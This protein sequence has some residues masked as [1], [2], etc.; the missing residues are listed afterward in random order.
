[1]PD[2]ADQ[3]QAQEE[4]F[5]GQALARQACSAGA[6]GAA[7]RSAPARCVECDDAIGIERRQA[8]PHACRCATCA[9]DHEYRLQVR[10]R[11]G[12]KTGADT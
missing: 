2:I 8:L 6:A 3:A 12:L 10:A 7:R 5:L 9:A 4:R 1:M 11:Q